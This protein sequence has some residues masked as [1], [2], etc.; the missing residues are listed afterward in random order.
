MVEGAVPS[1]K[2]APGGRRQAPTV[3]QVPSPTAIPRRMLS[4][5]GEAA[6]RSAHARAARALSGPP[7]AR[8]KT[9]HRSRYL[10]P[11]TPP[12]I[13]AQ[14]GHGRPLPPALATEFGS[15]LG[16]DLGHVLIHHDEAAAALA[17]AAQARAFTLGSHVFFGAGEYAPDRPAGRALLAHELAHAAE[18]GSD[19][20]PARL[21]R[22]PKSK[23]V[24]DTYQRLQVFSNSMDNAAKV[25]ASVPVSEGEQY[26]FIGMS[27]RFFKVYDSKANVLGRADTKDSENVTFFPGIY[28]EGPDGLDAITMSTLHPGR[29]STEV[30][31]HGKHSSLAF[32]R[33]RTEEEE[34]AVAAER[35]KAKAEKRKPKPVAIGTVAIRDMLRE[36][37]ALDSLTALAPH[38]AV[39][40]F[41]PT[42]DKMP[43]GGGPGGGGEQASAYASPIAGRGD[44]Q[45]PNAPPWPVTL[46]GP[47]LVPVGADPTFEAKIDWTQGGSYGMAAQV[48]SQVGENFGYRW[49]LFNITEY[50][51][52][53]QA[54]AAKKKKAGGAAAPRSKTLDE[55]IKEFTA[56]RPGTGQD[57]TG[58]GGANREFRREFED[59]WKDTKRASH[60]VAAPHGDTVAEQLSNAQANQLALELTP[61]SLIIT[62]IHAVLTWAADLFAGPRKQQEIPLETA[63]IFFI[64][65]ITTP[66]VTE[67]QGKQVIRAP[68]VASKV[69]NVE[70][71]DQTVKESLDEP[72]AQLA[73]LQQQI[74]TALAH[75]DVDR[76]RYLKHLLDE[77]N[78][79]FF[80]SPRDFLKQR[81]QQVETDLSLSPY[82]RQRNLE[83][84]DEQI[85]NYEAHEKERTKGATGLVGAARVQASLISEVTGEQYP[86]LLVAG[87][88]PKDGD[89]YRWMLSDVTTG[90]GD[91]YTGQGATPS[92]AFKSALEKFAAK[93][94]YGRGR[95][96]VRTSGLGLEAGAR[97]TIFVDS[98]PADWALAMKRI[99]DLVT[100]LIMLGLIV[101]SAGTAGALIGAGAAAAKLIQRWQAGHLSLDSETVGDVL[102]LL[103]GLGAAGQL[104]GE[105]RVVRFKGAFTI[106]KEG[107]AT[108]EELARAG[109]LVADAESLAAKAKAANGVIGHAGMIW[110]D[111]SVVDSMVTINAQ[112]ERGEIT[113]AAARRGRAQAI[114][115]AL[116]NHMIQIAE[117]ATGGKAGKAGGAAPHE[118]AAREHGAHEQ[119]AREPAAGEH[120][121][122]AADEHER[123][124]EA[125]HAP[126]PAEP[127]STHE[128]LREA[129]PANLRDLLVFGDVKGDAA[130]IDWKPDADGLVG[131]IEIHAGPETTP[132]MLRLHVE[133]V[134]TLQK[135]QGFGGRIRRALSWVADLIG[136][137]T[138]D[139]T[140]PEFATKLEIDKL[141][142]IV[143]EQM[144]AMKAMEPDARE[145]AEAKL[146]I[147]R[148]QLDEHMAALDIGEVSPETS[149]AARGVPKKNLKKYRELLAELRQLKPGSEAHM[150]KRREMYELTGGKLPLKSWEKIYKANMKNAIRAAKIVEGERARLG[151]PE[152]TPDEIPMEGGAARRLDLAKPVTRE[153][154]EV[155]AYR[156]GTVYRSPDVV[157]EV[158]RD[159][160][161]VKEMHWKITW[162]FVDC[163]PSGPLV[164]QLRRSGIIIEMRTFVK[165]GNSELKGRIY[166]LP[167]ARS[168]R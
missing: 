70:E 62:A 78:V 54:K 113:H 64:R 153:G 10:P 167:P 163:E 162:I 21:L 146:D 87:P 39:I 52:K 28:R 58:M 44:G 23:A 135:Y 160:K 13:A 75:H 165:G 49:E 73:E 57:V 140:K 127:H 130:R 152:G 65:V 138:L 105:L 164:E 20:G 9:S 18:A 3:R 100:T 32:R 40:Y 47:K 139:H 56:S 11:D 85:K 106:M 148:S 22:Q 41:V 109:K 115:S 50:I 122:T 104:V 149:V 7:A 131:K 86:L 142:R 101:E 99:D 158:E 14:A 42:F 30:D 123:I 129:L 76:A 166:P 37:N 51:K 69:V 82:T 53:E 71:M 137:E 155:K 154:V 55:R 118:P 144:N 19:P 117:L 95:I 112:E 36:P 126:V 60:G 125:P 88:M 110:G 24:H 89:Q 151:W 1:V 80:G 150:K 141:K 168:S 161:I 145:I 97:D 116:Q 84:I 67:F 96:G 68:S 35:Q 108:E 92:A 16:E 94:A 26:L 31:E 45:P 121:E 132:E 2:A 83:K 8:G 38:T 136:V 27:P 33:P 43:S 12:A 34:Q 5:P 46:D 103:G 102:G 29:L 72:S 90:E 25:L 77:A 119:A 66:A 79:R 91:A 157:D 124:P 98:A 128:R 159:A 74:D 107:A 15:R 134:Y 61:A 111:V 63:G 93:A 81:K 59:W 147:L 48:I 17:D 4:E 6:E 156:E 143:T 114:S 133:T 120:D